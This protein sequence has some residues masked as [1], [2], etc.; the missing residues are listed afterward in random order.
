MRSIKTKLIAIILSIVVVALALLG[1]VSYWNARNILVADTEENLVSLVKAHANET[2]LWLSIRTAEISLLANSPVLLSGDKDASI[3]YLSEEL[4]H[5]AFYQF[6][7]VTD[8]KGNA[9]NTIKIPLNVAD[10]DYF[11]NAVAQGRT[12]VSNPIISKTDGKQLVMVVA[13][14]KKNGQIVGTVGG[15]VAIDDL[16]KRILE[17]KVGKSGYGFVKQSDGLTI[18]HPDPN[19]MMRYNDLEDSA[20]DPQVKAVTGE[21][22]KGHTGLSQYT[23]QGTPQYLAY[24]P[25]PGMSW[26]L[27]MNVPVAE[28]TTKLK[29]LTLSW[30]VLM[31]L[32][33]LFSVIAANLYGRRLATPLLALNGI[34]ARVAGGDLRESELKVNSRDEIG[35]LAKSFDVMLGSLRGIVKQVTNSAEQVSAAA[36]ELN[37]SSEQLAQSTNQVAASVTDMA[38]GAAETSTKVSTIG[39]AAHAFAQNLTAAADSDREIQTLVQET[40]TATEKGYQAV[41][42]VTRQMQ[43]INEETA[44]VQGTIQHLSSSSK[45]IG[46]IVSL[47]SSIAGQT[48]LLALNAAI[49]AAR[50]GEQGRGF[51]VVAEE[52][53]KLAEQSQRAAQEIEELIKQN[54]DNLDRAVSAMQLG[55]DGVAEGTAVVNTAGSEFSRISELVQQLSEHC[56]VSSGNVQEA[57]QTGGGIVAHIDNIG[58]ISENLAEQTQAISAVVEEQSATTQEIAA[59]SQELAKMAQE[60]NDAIA[61][62]R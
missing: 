2:G 6:F 42:N 36:E 53:R 7:F 20:A 30:L 39:S 3:R 12:I 34:A 16:V 28:V 38:G 21:M 27:S 24:A 44:S 1:S 5:N 15:A 52:V 60:L 46:D 29:E 41:A 57:S 14:L 19:I 47:I 11:K 8:E 26:S 49:E 10:R 13:P 22:I 58:V 18:I 32:T 25:I 31:A 48:N 55:M 62:F 35:Q 50:A 33:L 37:A 56:T 9:T 51:A 43:K 40:A 17:I 45:E 4:N 59:S 23:W 54:E 61:V